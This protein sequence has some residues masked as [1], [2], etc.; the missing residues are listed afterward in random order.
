MNSFFH[1]QNL[2][3]VDTMAPGKLGGRFLLPNAASATL[4]LTL[5]CV[6]CGCFYDFL[7]LFR[8][9]DVTYTT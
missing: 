3:G 5:R 2:V 7:L 6:E 8:G 1:L 4:A 9:A